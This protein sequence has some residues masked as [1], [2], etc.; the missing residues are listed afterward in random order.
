M[1][2]SGKSSIGALVSKKLQLNFYDIDKI[3][4]KEMD[5]KISKIFEIRGENYFRNIEE[6]ITLK[7]LKKKQV[8]ISLGGGAFLNEN[9]KNEIL[10]NH[11]SF[12]L[13]LDNK[14][15]IKRIKFSH[16]RPIAYKLSN[17]EITNLIKIRSNFYSKALYKI[18]C[19]NLSKFEVMT[20]VLNLYETN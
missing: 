5:M 4:E 9:I 2:G 6:K 7:I 10:K 19:N 12:W 20:K 16:K 13:K 11:L 14:T 8:V 18:N 1:M 3:I 15:L 17:N